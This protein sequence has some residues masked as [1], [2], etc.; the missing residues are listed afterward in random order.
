[1]VVERRRGREPESSPSPSLAAGGG[2]ERGL[3]ALL[4]EEP[5]SLP[6]AAEELRPEEEEEEDEEAEDEE[7]L[8][9]FGG[10]VEAFSR[11]R[12]PDSE[13]LELRERERER[14][15]SSSRWRRSWVSQ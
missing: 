9:R 6:L 1:V 7:E 8:R 14:R 3:R 13:R 12:S 2:V 15:E 4:E 10:A 5:E 11:G